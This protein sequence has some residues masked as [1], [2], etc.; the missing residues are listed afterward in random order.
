MYDKVRNAYSLYGQ[1]EADNANFIKAEF[2]DLVEQAYLV[3]PE[4]TESK[5]WVYFDLVSLMCWVLYFDLVSQNLMCWVYFDLVSQMCWVYF[6]LVSQ[7]CWVYFDLAC[8][9]CT[10]TFLL[11]CR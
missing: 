8:A 4:G 2:E 3:S 5:C 6:D 1:I 7:M 9:G 10:L 11:P